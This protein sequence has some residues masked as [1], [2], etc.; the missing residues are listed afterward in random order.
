MRKSVNQLANHYP[1][2]RKLRAVLKISDI[3]FFPFN[4]ASHN[5][6]IL[7]IYV[8]QE[9]LDSLYQTLPRAFPGITSLPKES[10][11]WLDAKLVFEGKTYRAKIR[12]RGQGAIHWRDPKKSFKIKLKDKQKIFD[13]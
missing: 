8:D 9:E 11:K 12:L 6:P 7:N 5:L 3:C 2:I 4:L 13:M 10:R 1:E